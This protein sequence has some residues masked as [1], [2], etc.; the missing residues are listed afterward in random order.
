MN[1]ELFVLVIG[2]G[3]LGSQLALDMLEQGYKIRILDNRPAVLDRLHGM[4]PTEVIVVG[5]P[6]QPRALAEAGIETANVVAVVMPKD[7]QNLA[8]ASFA[9]FQ[10]NVPR[11]IARVNEPRNAWL[12]TPEM[13]VDVAV[14]QAD[15]L[16][17]LIQEE[18]SM[19]DMMTL[20]KL[21]RGEYSVVEEK[22]PA[23]AWAIGMEIRELDLPENCVIAAIIRQGKI[24]VPHGFS[25]LEA[26]DEVLAVTDHE[27][28]RQLELL[29]A[30][31][32]QE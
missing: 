15:I 24:V 7:S 31:L 12:F 30:P 5:D 10:F 3:R 28:A 4:V 18:M 9:R 26:G 20:L 11:V 32:K 8:I 29:F 17:S 19:G 16:G 25:T 6:T 1:K 2:G 23:D 14:N 21:H 13:G 22:I 27:G